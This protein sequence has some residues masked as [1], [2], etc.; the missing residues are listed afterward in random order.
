MA[1]NVV[2]PG[3][4]TTVQDLG[5]PGYFHLGIP[6]GGAMDRLALRSANLLVGNDEGRRGPRGCV[7]RPRT[8][9]HEGRC[10]RSDRRGN[11]D[12]DRRRRAP[13]WTALRIKAG[14]ILSFGYLQ[15]GARIY[16]AI[17]GGIDVPLALGSRATY[18][19]GALGGY[20][21]RAIAKSDVL[22]V[23]RSGFGWRR[24]DSSATTAPRPGNACRTAGDARALLAQSH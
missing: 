2:N 6:I 17:S 21:G 22:P 15:R 23:G 9:I 1:V 4:S 8:G 13:S 5:R 20:K 12:Q 18:P 10:R 19:I 3:L 16:I 7:H 14:H 24:S 11:A